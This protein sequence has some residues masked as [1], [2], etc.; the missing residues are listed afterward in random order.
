MQGTQTQRAGQLLCDRAPVAAR[1]ARLHRQQGFVQDPLPQR[2]AQRAQ[3]VRPLLLLR[4]QER[5][6]DDGERLVRPEEDL[7]GHLAAARAVVAQE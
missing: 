7:Q 3:I 6:G 5:T 1:L 2:L 4:P